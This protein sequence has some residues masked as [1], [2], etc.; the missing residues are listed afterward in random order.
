MESTNKS[1]FAWAD[2][3]NLPSSSLTQH[4]AEQ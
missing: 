2:R 4:R 1:N 3:S